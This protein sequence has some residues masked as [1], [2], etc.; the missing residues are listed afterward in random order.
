MS[1]PALYRE[2]LRKKPL[3]FGLTWFLV[4]NKVASIF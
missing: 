3:G 4:K 2:E 1:A